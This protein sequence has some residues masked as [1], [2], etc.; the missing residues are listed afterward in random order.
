M[1]DSDSDLKCTDEIPSQ[2]VI[3]LARLFLPEIQAF[4]SSN[5]GNA[6]AEIKANPKA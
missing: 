2:V 6:F 3:S 4:Y 1:S 5:E